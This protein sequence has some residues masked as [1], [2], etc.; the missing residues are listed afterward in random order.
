L[1]DQTT[2]WQALGISP[3][4]EIA[5][6]RR[7]YAARLKECHPEENPEGFQRLRA[8]YEAALRA[9]RG[10]ADATSS[11]PPTAVREATAQVPP[12]APSSG[13]ISSQASDED[14]RHFEGTVGR[15]EQLLRT[16]GQPDQ[17]TLEGAL[18]AVLDS[19]GAFH[20]G[21]WSVLDRR[22]A[23]LLVEAVPKSDPILDTVVQRLGWAH[24]DVVT[25]RAKEVVAI[26][27]RVADLATVAKLRSGR[28]AD[29]RVFHLF[30]QPAPKSWLVRRVK[31][32]YFDPAV[33]D[34]INK[35]LRARP[36]LAQWLD[37]ASVDIWL[38]IFWRP[39]VSERGLVA[40][41]I[42]SALALIGTYIADAFGVLP[43]D[44]RGTAFLLALC[45]GPGLVLLKLYAFS[46]PVTLVFMRLK[47]KKP[48]SW[49]R[50]GWLGAGA[51]SVLLVSSLPATWPVVAM[52]LALSAGVLVWATVAAHPVFVAEGLGFYQKL[53]LVL[54]E[55]PLVLFWTGMVGWGVGLPA[56]IA[57][58][59]AFGAN[60]IAG[61]SMARMWKFDSAAPI[62]YWSLVALSVLTIAAFYALWRS[63]DSSLPIGFSMALV[64]VAAVMQ[65]PARLSLSQDLMVR[66]FKARVFVTIAFFV[67]I[68][69]GSEAVVQISK[70][71]A[72][73]MGGTYVLLGV[74][75][76]VCFVV[77][78]E[79]T[80]SRLLRRASAQSQ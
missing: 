62:R 28:D 55:S 8:A 4:R 49:V 63:S 75:A 5:D 61:R 12:S 21:T 58:A 2:V 53:K 17:A 35:T 59:G 24:A 41:P 78:S 66:W 25:A 34:F 18:T 67:V 22:L 52:S 39:H 16:P 3:T 20:V 47:E 45:V 23:R 27:T 11:L 13:A 30:S 7:A 33:R 38:K 76:T 46:W 79:A 1:T 60:A 69:A 68:A 10:A 32:V 71:V 31:A 72:L 6:I 44:S 51:L 15:L 74:V 57:T 48:P 14:L 70:R 19:P 37:K 26:V 64:T 50:W 40:M 36:T 80:T 77:Y 65:R 73:Q 29:A 54:V 56:C 9:A 42:F 43:P